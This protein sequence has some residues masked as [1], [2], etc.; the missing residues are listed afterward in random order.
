MR[1]IDFILY[2]TCSSVVRRWRD[3]FIDLC[4]TTIPS[5]RQRP[6]YRHWVL[7]QEKRPV[8]SCN[9]SNVQTKLPSLIVLVE[10]ITWLKLVCI[11]QAN[12]PVQAHK[13]RLGSV[14]LACYCD[15]ITIESTGKA[16]KKSIFSL[17]NSTIFISLS[18]I[19]RKG[20]VIFSSSPRIVHTCLQS[21]WF[22]DLNRSSKEKS[23]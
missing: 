20:N 3:S 15:L 14:A 4:A 17:T 1:V 11:I 5:P 16:A 21:T 9:T 19:G 7:R 10:L 2:S 6:L 18:L 12:T 8:K 22:S 23:P 13:F